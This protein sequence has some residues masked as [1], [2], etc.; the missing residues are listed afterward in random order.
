MGSHNVSQAHGKMWCQA[1]L[2]VQLLSLSSV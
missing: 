1:D 2:K